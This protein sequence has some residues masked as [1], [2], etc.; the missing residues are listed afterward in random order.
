ML[1]KSDFIQ[2]NKNMLEITLRTEIMS[3]KARR[4]VSENFILNTTMVIET[5]M[6]TAQIDRLE[7]SLAEVRSYE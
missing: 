1:T 5:E 4:G 2:L 7:K 6:L 3:L